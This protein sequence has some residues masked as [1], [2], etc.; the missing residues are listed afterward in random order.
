MPARRRVGMPG[1]GIGLPGV[2]CP[3]MAVCQGVSAQGCVCV[4]G[5]FACQGGV[6]PG[7]CLPAK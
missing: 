1:G 5:V 7:G 2:V 6:C 4:Q 3:G